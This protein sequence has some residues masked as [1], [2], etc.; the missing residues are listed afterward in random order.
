MKKTIYLRIILFLIVI[1]FLIVTAVADDEMI[2]E[3]ANC[4]IDFS[5]YSLDELLLR[6][7][8]ST[9]LHGR[10]GRLPESAKHNL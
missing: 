6:I 2:L 4:P 10:R 8:N 5:G 9:L 7:K 1:P 3:E